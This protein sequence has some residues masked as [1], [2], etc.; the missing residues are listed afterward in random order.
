MVVADI[1]A[2]V[3][4]TSAIL[5]LRPEVKKVYAV[6]PSK[7]RLSTNSKPGNRGLRL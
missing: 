7:S 6:E 4:W 1:G 5:A 2:G 3:G